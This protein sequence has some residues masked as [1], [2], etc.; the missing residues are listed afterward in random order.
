MYVRS[1]VRPDFQR[2]L[3]RGCGWMLLDGLN[4]ELRFLKNFEKKVFEVYNVISM[5]FALGFDPLLNHFLITF[6]SFVENWI[7]SVLLGVHF[8][9]VCL[10]ETIHKINS[11]HGKVQNFRAA[12]AVKKSLS[13]LSFQ[14][15]FCI[16]GTLKIFVY[17][18]NL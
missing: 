7:L 4:Y 6:G 9:K 15:K 11:K 16:I 17:L 12:R 2:C 13:N 3:R 10:G 1:S 8:N 18:E 14:I 5:R